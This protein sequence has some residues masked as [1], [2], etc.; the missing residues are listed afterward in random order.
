MD[1]SKFGKGGELARVKLTGEILKILEEFATFSVG[2]SSLS[3]KYIDIIKKYQENI[4]LS[5]SVQFSISEI[6]CIS[7]YQ[8]DENDPAWRAGTPYLF[9]KK[10]L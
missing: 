3:D 6:P 9:R 8:N 1:Q 4:S 5:E 7:T 2:I 10:K